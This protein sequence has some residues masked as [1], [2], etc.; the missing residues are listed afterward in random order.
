MRT[1]KTHRLADADNQVSFKVAADA[2]K[3]EI[4]G[5]MKLLFNV[6]AVSVQVVNMRGKRTRMGRNVGWRSNWKKAYIKLAPGQD[7]DFAVGDN[8]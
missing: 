3:T 8:A 7:I 4:K 6:D 5:A 1:E 2:T